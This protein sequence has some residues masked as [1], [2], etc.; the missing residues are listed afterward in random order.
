MWYKI[1]GDGNEIDIIHARNTQ[2]AI[3]IARKRHGEA[4][5]TWR[6]Y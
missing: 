4:V 6:Y 2:E 5:Y 3:D 1:F